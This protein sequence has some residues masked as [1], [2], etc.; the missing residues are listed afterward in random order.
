MDGPAGGG[1]AGEDEG[2]GEEGD[3]FHSGDC[4]GPHGR[5]HACAGHR[6]EYRETLYLPVAGRVRAVAAPHRCWHCKGRGWGCRATERCTP[7][8]E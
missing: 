3:D 4:P 1:A 2:G 7:R 8:H 6:V 5:C